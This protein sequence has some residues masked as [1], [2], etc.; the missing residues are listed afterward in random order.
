[1]LDTASAEEIKRHY[2]EKNE[3]RRVSY[4]R[5]IG[6]EERRVLVEDKVSFLSVDSDRHRP[7]VLLVGCVRQFYTFRSVAAHYNNSSIMIHSHCRRRRH[8]TVELRR[9]W[10]CEM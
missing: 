9:V 8:E 5:Q 2:T 1:M 6:T 3:T 4:R 7:R 10:W